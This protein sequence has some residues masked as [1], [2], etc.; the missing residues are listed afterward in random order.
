MIEQP[1]DIDSRYN[2]ISGIMILPGEGKRFPC[3]ILSHGLVSSKESSKYTEV[4][5]RF[6]EAGL[7]SCRFDYHGCGESG[8]NIEDTSLTIRLGNLDAITEYVMAHPSVDPGKIGIIGSSFGGSTALLKAAHD[9][10]IK[11]LS[12]WATPYI[13]ENK[14]DGNISDIQFKYTI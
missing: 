5:R 9:D 6:A 11:C 8:G 10:R 12:L 3:A 7:A 14:D 2:K 4:S 1:F 13:L